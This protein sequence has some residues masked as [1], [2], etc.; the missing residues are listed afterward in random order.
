MYEY[1]REAGESRNLSDEEKPSEEEN[2]DVEKSEDKRREDEQ[3]NDNII[4]NSEEGTEISALECLEL[5]FQRKQSRSVSK[6][7]VSVT[8]K[9]R[10]D[11][12][13]HTTANSTDE[14]E[15]KNKASD[16]VVT[17]GV[18]AEIQSMKGLMNG[19]LEEM[20]EKFEKVK[21]NQQRIEE[22]VDRLVSLITTRREKRD[23]RINET[24]TESDG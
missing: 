17:E 2:S 22:K 13:S 9:E 20:R 1:I 10:K 11:G 19:I 14:V 12:F 6:P 18:L 21:G 7:P 5:V 3:L 15:A 4:E 24:R 23:R 16:P 8:P